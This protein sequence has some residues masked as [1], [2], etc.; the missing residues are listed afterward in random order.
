MKVIFF[1][2]NVEGIKMMKSRIDLADYFNELGFKVGAEIGTADGRFAEILCQRIEGLKLLC[3]DPW[4]RYEGNWRSENYQKVAYLTA[5]KRLKNYNADLIKKTGV[6]ASLSVPDN[7]LDFVFID[8]DHQFDAVMTDI[9]LWSKKVKSGGIV[10][11]H[12][13]YFHKAGGV[14]PAVNKYTEV[15][16]IELNIIQRYSEG[17]R[18]DRVPCVWWRKP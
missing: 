2:M 11:L 10:S 12:D 7:S 1:V 9:I 5:Q 4:E 6:E 13:Y 17:H 15:H 14:V 18:D 8:G 3:I 16:E